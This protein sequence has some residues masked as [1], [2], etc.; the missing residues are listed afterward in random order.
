MG[1]LHRLFS[2]KKHPPGADANISRPKSN[3]DNKKKNTTKDKNKDNYNNSFD[4]STFSFDANRHA[5]AVAAATAAAAEA[6]LAAAHAASEVVRLTNGSDA[7]ASSRAASVSHVQRRLVEE[8]AAVKIQ[9]AFRGYLVCETVDILYVVL[10]IVV[11]VKC[12]MFFVSTNDIC[13]HY[14][15]LYLSLQYHFPCFLFVF[16]FC[17]W[18]WCASSALFSGFSSLSCLAF[19]TFIYYLILCFLFYFSKTLYFTLTMLKNIT[20]FVKKI[21]TIK[22]LIYKYTI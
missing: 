11:T 18:F 22:F 7:G 2:R 10:E 17:V 13:S 15:I 5:I 16:M 21:I 4:R 3:K 8:T 9:S 14:I 19:R 6:A 1:F 12:I 20:N